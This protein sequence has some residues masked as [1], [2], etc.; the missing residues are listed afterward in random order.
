MYSQ[1][2]SKSE[3]NIK[4]GAIH[5][6][7]LSE[8]YKEVLNEGE[9]CFNK[10]GKI[11]SFIL[12]FDKSKEDL[13]LSINKAKSKYDYIYVVIDDSSKRRELEKIVPEY[14]GIFCYSNAFGNGNVIQIFREPK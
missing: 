8:G 7:C 12:E 9:I 14:C 4:C 10:E 2:E 6:W 3:D 5:L 1:V 13:L 11:T